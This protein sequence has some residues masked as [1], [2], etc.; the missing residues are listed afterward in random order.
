MIECPTCSFENSEDS[1]YCRRCG[2]KLATAGLEDSTV[3]YPAP[4][5]DQKQIARRPSAGAAGPAL[6]I[7]SG[8]GREGELVVL[9]TDVLTIGRNPDNH[10]FLDDVTV[11]R[12][13]ARILRDGRGYLIED[14][15]SLNGTYVNRRRIERH[16]LRDG[17]EL[18]IG[19]YKLVFLTK[20]ES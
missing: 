18:Q 7:R 13:H 5:L 9:E 4:E 6:Q 8:G 1:N 20:A 14:L 11:S 17:D 16:R 12:R 2:T 15:R 19:K 3:S 10:L